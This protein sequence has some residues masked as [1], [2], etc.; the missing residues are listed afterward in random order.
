MGATS[1]QAL[2]ILQFI[3][4]AGWVLLPLAPA[5]LIYKLFPD[6]QTG[7]SGPFSGLTIRAT[8]A[9]AAYFIVFLA[10]IPFL[11]AINRNLQSEFHP[12]W[13]I[14]GQIFPKDV[15]GRPISIDEVDRGSVQIVFDPT[16]LDLSQ[17]LRFTA[18]VPEIDGRVPTVHILYPGAGTYTMNPDHPPPEFDVDIDNSDRMITIHS[19]IVIRNKPCLG[20]DCSSAE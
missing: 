11:N 6:T 4:N 3:L 10:T 18:T 13:R 2:V 19:P 7:F 20:I 16:G 5:I 14:T 15:E 1:G 8:G 17:D 12:T 9:F